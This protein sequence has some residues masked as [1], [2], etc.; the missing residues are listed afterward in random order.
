[1]DVFSFAFCISV[2][3]EIKKSNAYR[4]LLEFV[5]YT[6]FVSSNLNIWQFEMSLFELSQPSLIVIITIKRIIQTS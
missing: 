1:M 3:A 6:M 4:R 2:L 5:A